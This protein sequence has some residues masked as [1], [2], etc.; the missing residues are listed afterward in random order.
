MAHDQRPAPVVDHRLAPRADDDFRPDAGRIA[1][2]TAISGLE[3]C[4]ATSWTS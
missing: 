3:F 1:L 4:M 2:V